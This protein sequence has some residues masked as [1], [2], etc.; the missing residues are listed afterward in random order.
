MDRLVLASVPFDMPVPQALQSIR[1]RTRAIVVTGPHRARLVTAGDIMEASNIALDADRD[2]ASVKVGEVVSAHVP[3]KALPLALPRNFK[4]AGEFGRAQFPQ[5]TL[6]ERMHFESAFKESIE[7]SD[8]RY[9]IQH[10]GPD[11][12]VV[13]T[14]SEYFTA[15]LG[16]NV[17]ICTCVGDPKHSFEPRQLRVPGKCNKP[18]G[19]PV[20]C[21]SVGVS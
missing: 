20:T 2:P 18:H 3:I 8:T 16:D 1:P 10:L 9:I 5:L 12:A 11:A 6:E 19:V 14:A 4:L 17:T 7:S 13:V 21:R 15:E